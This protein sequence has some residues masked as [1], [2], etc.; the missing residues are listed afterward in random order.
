MSGADNMRDDT[1]FE[2]NSF[3]SYARHGR[4]LNW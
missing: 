2:I 1:H 4:K 3:F